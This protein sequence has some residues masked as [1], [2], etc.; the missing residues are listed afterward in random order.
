MGLV[1]FPEGEK[2]NLGVLE[3]DE[4]VRILWLPKGWRCWAK[5]VNTLQNEIGVFYKP[6]FKCS[7]LSNNI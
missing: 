5:K 3:A 6:Y 1:F 2:Y 4:V 7:G